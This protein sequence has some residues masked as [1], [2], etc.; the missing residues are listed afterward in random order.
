[1]SLTGSDSFDIWT[2]LQPPHL[3]AA[4][5]FTCAAC[6]HSSSRGDWTNNCVHRS[7]CWRL[8]C[9]GKNCEGTVIPTG[10][11][12]G[13][14]DC[15]TVYIFIYE[16]EKSRIFQQRLIETRLEVQEVPSREDCTIGDILLR[17]LQTQWKSS[18]SS[19]D[20]T[21]IRSWFGRGKLYYTR[22]RKASKLT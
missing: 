4:N 7:S 14:T 18:D 1:M 16:G 12:V 13:S 22:K 11:S 8:M 5:A 2:H 21:R 20:S 15:F 17:S 3:S 6:W 10:T 19:L 9:S